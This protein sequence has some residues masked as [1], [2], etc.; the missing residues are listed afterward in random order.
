LNKVQRRN[1]KPKNSAQLKEGDFQQGSK[2][3]SKELDAVQEL[4]TQWD[5]LDIRYGGMKLEQNEKVIFYLLAQGL[6]QK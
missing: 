4:Q 2:K 6:S 1:T 3:I 5:A